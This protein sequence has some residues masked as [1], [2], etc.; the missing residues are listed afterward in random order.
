MLCILILDN[1]SAHDIDMTQFLSKL[2]IKFLPPN[3]NNIH[4]PTGMRM[5]VSLKFE[6]KSLYLRILLDI[7]DSEGGYEQAAIRRNKQK[8]G[9]KGAYYGGKPHVL[10]CMEMLSKIWKGKDGKYISDKS[11][12]RCWRKADIWLVT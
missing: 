6:H 8:R 3:I 10:D 9:C 7:L 5:I 2:I 4:Q 12:Y 1:Y 11:V